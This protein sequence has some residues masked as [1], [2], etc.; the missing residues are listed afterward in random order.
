[1]SLAAYTVAFWR[2][3]TRTTNL[4]H[5]VG[6]AAYTTVTPQQES[7]D[8]IRSRI[9]GSHIGNGLRSGRKILRKKLVGDKIANYYLEP[10]SKLDPMFVDLGLERCA[11]TCVDWTLK[12]ANNMWRIMVRMASLWL[13]R[14][15][16]KLDKLRRRGKAPPKKGEG[17]RA[18]KRK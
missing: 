2:H 12:V 8:E 3:L 9:F 14:K 10:I 16:M 15:K 13:C 17:K 11:V 1:M 7:L 4:V 5:Q 18:G 6:K